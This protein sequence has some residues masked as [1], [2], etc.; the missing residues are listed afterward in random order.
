M[1]ST[2]SP[3]LWLPQVFILASILAACVGWTLNAQAGWILLRRG[4]HHRQRMEYSAAL[5]DYSRAAELK[6]TDY[7]PYQRMGSIYLTQGRLPEA[8]GALRQALDLN[9]TEVGALTDLAQV[10]YGVGQQE[11]AVALWKRAASFPKSSEAR[12]HLGIV[13]LE[14]GELELARD[15][16]ILALEIDPTRTESRYWLA[17]LTALERPEEAEELLLKV[18]QASSS[19]KLEKSARIL[20]EALRSLEELADPVSRSMVL[21]SA[22]LRVDALSLAH[23]RFCWALSQDPS[24]LEAQAHVGYVL[25]REGKRGEAARDL[26]HV[27]GQDED[28]LLANYYLGLVL[29]SWGNTE[30]AIA[31]FQ[32][33]LKADPE[34]AAA[35][36]E[37]GRAYYH[38]REYG[39]AAEMLEKGA[40]LAPD[41]AG[42]H[43]ILARFYVDHLWLVEE[44]GLPEATWAASL[45]PGDAEIQDVL[46]WANYLTERYQEAETAL[47]TAIIID[48]SLASAH[49]HLGMTLQQM[50]R[51]EEAVRALQKAADLDAEGFYRRRAANELDELGEGLLQ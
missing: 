34:N 14:A 6:P 8:E 39:Q 3:L 35:Y 25:F 7:R 26:M 49:Y 42:F 48:P 36:M 12:Y 30:D 4:D 13:A 38:R 37:M 5:L 32:A 11:A 47:M 10:L 41:D 50:G 46:A 28:H 27:L 9:P 43:L 31:Q 21:G 51:Q 18:L 22:Y 29:L 2:K 23:E 45:A 17:L 44:K 33:V 19:P 40:R 15:E 24:N 1:S 20:L 16:L